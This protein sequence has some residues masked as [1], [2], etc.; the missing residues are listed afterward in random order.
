MGA[1]TNPER[2]R[3]TCIFSACLLC[4]STALARPEI[5]DRL[6]LSAS[7]DLRAVF[8]DGEESWLRPDGTGKVRFGG[9][10]NGNVKA[11][12]AL[13]D[14][15]VLLKPTF[16]DVQLHADVHVQDQSKLR[17]GLN[18]A[19]LAWKPVP[20]GD[21]RISARAGLFYP[22]ISLEHYGEGWT[23]TRTLTPSAINS[24]V[25]EEVKG[26]GVEAKVSTTLGDHEAA[27][28]AAVFGVNDTAGTLLTFRGWALHDI[29]SN[30][31]QRQPLP[32]LS[33]FAKYLQPQ[34]STPVY[35]LDN[36]P[37][38]Y[39]R[40]DWRLPSRIALNAM[41]Y[42]NRGN[43]EAVDENLEWSWQTRFVNIGLSYDIDDTTQLLA[44]A[45]TG[46]TK[47]G[48]RQGNDLW[49]DVGFTSA[50]ALLSRDVWS[51]KITARGDW[52]E[53]K[54]H[55]LQ[56]ID[57]NA[58]TGWSMTAAYARPVYRGTTVILEA[59][60]VSST[61]PAR[62]VA[63]RAAKSAQTQLQAAIRVGF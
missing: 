11:R 61:R 18:E 21:T 36:R 31:Y 63:H 57:N 4:S 24:W 15:H 41:W 40:A 35:E 55:T 27:L 12:V 38:Y 26:V 46:S 29:M 10:S 59:L 13:G 19:W 58:E 48:F 5:L 3:A 50:Y 34:F 37:G 8:A 45:M 43:R 2:V 42:D 16:G 51:G 33:E 1:K 23:T 54:D 9:D 32:E 28:T 14:A 22:P 7:L 39:V 56:S 60:H 17:F 44:Q 25:G 20:T 47:M 30:A 53:V 62:A 6:G 52:F 49:F